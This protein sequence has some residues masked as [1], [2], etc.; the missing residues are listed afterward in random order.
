[1]DDLKVDKIL[2]FNIDNQ[3][4]AL[5]FSVVERVIRIVEITP[6]PKAA[7]ILSGMINMHGAV[8][9]VIDIR[10]LLGLSEREV[11]L[12]DRLI[13]TK[14]AGVKVALLIDDI[15]GVSE[16]RE[17]DIIPT[18]KIIPGLEYIE[19][20][21]KLADGLVFIYDLDKFLLLDERIL[22]SCLP[23]GCAGTLEG[24]VSGR[25]GVSE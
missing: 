14:T 17:Q 13:I 9:P 11:S 1:M 6:V 16:Y 7:E 12:S 23:G 19:G 18:G 4:Y 5:H 22:K 10:R 24:S 8:L 2:I 25:V 15:I 21:V 3:K 20:V